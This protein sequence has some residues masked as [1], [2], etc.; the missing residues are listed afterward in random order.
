MNRSFIVNNILV[1]G[2]STFVFFPLFFMASSPLDFHFFDLRIFL[3]CFLSPAV[4]FVAAGI[5]TIFF[6]KK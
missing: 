6:Y 3:I 5:T 1:S 2:F 4:L